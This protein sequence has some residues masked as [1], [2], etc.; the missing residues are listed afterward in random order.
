LL[1][2]CPL[3]NVDMMWTMHSSPNAQL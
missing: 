3:P 2:G 1:D